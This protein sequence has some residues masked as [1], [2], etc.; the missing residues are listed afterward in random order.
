MQSLMP[1]PNLTS[2]LSFLQLRVFSTLS[3]IDY[4]SVAYDQAVP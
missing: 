1:Q 2:L 3:A 4:P